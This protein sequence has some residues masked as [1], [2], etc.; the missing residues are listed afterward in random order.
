[1]RF[2]ARIISF[3]FMASHIVPG[4]SSYFAWDTN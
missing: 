4:V 1:M 3:V 2:S